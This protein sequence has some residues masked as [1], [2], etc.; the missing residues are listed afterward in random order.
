M[1][2]AATSALMDSLKRYLTDSAAHGVTLY[3][4]AMIRNNGV[5][6]N[7]CRVFKTRGGVSLPVELV[8]VRARG[9]TCASASGSK[10]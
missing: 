6:S 10:C 1:R 8:T 4:V 9:C 2:P 5:L 3:A 7:Y